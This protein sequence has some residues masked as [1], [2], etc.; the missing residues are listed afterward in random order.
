MT[1]PEGEEFYFQWHITE[2]CNLRCKHCYHEDYR[3]EGE[4]TS[5]Q[6]DLAFSRMDTAL[7]KWGRQGSASLTGGEPFLRRDD[8]YRLAGMMDGSDRFNYYDIL[9]NGSL[10][11]SADLDRLRD[12]P[13]LRRVQVSLES[14]FPEKND[15]V[16]GSGSF[17]ATMSAI[18]LLKDRGLQVS[19]MTTITRDNQHDIPEMIELLACER[20]DTFAIERFI[21]EGAGTGIREKVL[22]REEVKRLYELVHQIGIR[23]KRIRV[24][25]YRPLFG[26]IDRDDCTV[27]AMCSIGTNALS[28]MHDG[29]IYPCRRL[30]IPI[31]NI[32]DDGVFKPWYDSDILWSIRDS[33]NLKGKCGSCELVPICRGCRAMAYWLSGDYLEEDPHCWK[34]PARAMC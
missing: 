17:A 9:T 1:E 20:V 19:V 18:R 10:I 32:L 5:Q 2:R 24:L 30:P 34:Q 6:L 14:P 8:L 11:T 23:E 3:S 4:L 7:E 12:L 21:P 26:L 13:K 29:T 28:I 22:S 27:G 15:K 16:R 25:M 31:G 33:S